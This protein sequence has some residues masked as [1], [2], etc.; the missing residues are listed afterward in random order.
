MLVGVTTFFDDIYIAFEDLVVCA[1]HTYHVPD[2]RS[3]GVDEINN[4]IGQCNSRDSIGNYSPLPAEVI[5]VA[6][7]LQT[8]DGLVEEIHSPFR[9]AGT[10]ISDIKII[11]HQLNLPVI[12]SEI[13][14]LN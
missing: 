1:F 10:R 12:E 8:Y 5:G 14:D 3:V 9:V 11:F 6:A 4:C 13:M 2:V 7:L